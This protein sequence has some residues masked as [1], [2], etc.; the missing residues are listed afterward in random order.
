LIAWYTGDACGLTAT[1]SSPPMWPNHS[2]VM[3]DT[4]EAHE[5]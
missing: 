1:L 4:I 2:A 3:I 5:A